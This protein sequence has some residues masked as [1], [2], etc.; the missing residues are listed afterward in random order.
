MSKPS[1]LALG[2]DRNSAIFFSESKSEL[3]RPNEGLKSLVR[4]LKTQWKVSR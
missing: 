4:K 2:K 1:G 3:F